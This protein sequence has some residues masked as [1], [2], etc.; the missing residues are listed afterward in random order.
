MMAKKKLQLGVLG[1]GGIARRRVL[2][3]LAGHSD[4]AVVAVM[5]V[6]G[7]AEIAAEFAVPKSFTDAADLVA[8]PSVE[9]VYIASPVFLHA[10]HIRLAAQAGKPIFC[11]KPVARTLAETTAA[12]EVCRRSG[13]PLMEGYMMN[14]H[15][16]HGRI[17]EL[18]TA[19]AIGRPVFMRA[20]LSCWY[21]PIAGAWRQDP[22]LGGG[23]SLIDMATHCF[24]LLEYL[25]GERIQSVFAQ[26]GNQVHQ[27]ASEDSATLLL[28]FASGCHATVD[29]FFCLRD[30]AS[31][32]RLEIYGTGGGILAEGT[33]G[34]GEGGSVRLITTGEDGGYDANQSRGDTLSGYQPVDFKSIN[35]YAAEFTH[36]AQCLAEDRPFSLNGPDEALHIA[37]VTEAAY[38]S[39]REGRMISDGF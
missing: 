20:Q 31:L 17:R 38:T 25:G 6:H 8:D 22:D 12:L 19:G 24:S 2:P 9:A 4:V 14:F 3:A 28:R 29:A 18:L 23:G 30:E 10:D 26:T 35:P 1:A 33:I 16:A 11:E 7:A 37:K 5:D 21:P 34:Q 36:F 27:Y 39:A 32:G 15:G 13:V